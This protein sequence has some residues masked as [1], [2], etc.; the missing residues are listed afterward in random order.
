MSLV[1]GNDRFTINVSVLL[2]PLFGCRRAAHKHFLEGDDGIGDHH[3]AGIS[4]WGCALWVIPAEV[5]PN[6]WQVLLFSNP[7][8]TMAAPFPE[9][10]K[11]ETNFAKHWHMAGEDA[12]S[13]WI[14]HAANS[15]LAAEYVFLMSP[16]PPR[17]STDHAFLADPESS[18]SI[19]VRRVILRRPP[20]WREISTS[21]YVPDSSGIWAVGSW[22]S[23]GPSTASCELPF[24]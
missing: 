17:L 16:L 20:P 22:N 23:S 3:T 10:K 2:P 7:A 13:R 8:L 12:Q 19:P 18:C 5:E 24:G 9:P 15:A 1:S 6:R 11:L 14:S 21:G 4:I